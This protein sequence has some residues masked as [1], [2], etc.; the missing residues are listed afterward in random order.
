M[1]KIRQNINTVIFAIILGLS[2][3]LLLTAVAEVTR[4]KQEENR[5]AEK[6]RNILSALKVPFEADSSPAD[7]I[8]IFERDVTEQKDDG[9]IALELYLYKPDGSDA[10]KAVAVHFE[11]PGLWGPVKGFLALEPDYQMIRGLTFYQQEE[12]PGLG[13]EI[14]TDDFRGRFEGRQIIGAEGNWGIDLIA[15]GSEAIAKNQIAGISGATMTCD[16]VEEM[17]NAVIE[18]LAAKRDSDGR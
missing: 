14:V 13:G 1:N 15:G 9:E 5:Q 12:T 11:G 6:I 2:C 18:T 10:V 8:V 4:P 16:K 3:A 17:I 7:L